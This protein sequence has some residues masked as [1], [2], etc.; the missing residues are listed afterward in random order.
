MRKFTS[1]LALVLCFF[2]ALGA[3]AQID[4]NKIIDYIGEPLVSVEEF[5]DGGLYLIT[6]VGRHNTDGQWLYETTDNSLL[7]ESVAEGHSANAAFTIEVVGDEQ[8]RIKTPSGNYV[9]VFN[10]SQGTFKS[11]SLEPATFII[12]PIDGA[13]G[14]FTL[15]YTDAN[16][17]LDANAANLSNW[18]D[19][20]GAGG[21]GAFRF[22]PVELGDP[23]AAMYLD[24]VLEKI[25]FDESEYLRDVPGGYP[26]ELIDAC[27]EAYDIA[28]DYQANGGDDDELREAADNLQAAYDAL[29]AAQIQVAFEPGNYYL[30]NARIGTSGNVLADAEDLSS[31][32]AAYAEGTKALWSENFDATIQGEEANPAY[33]W[34]IEAAGTNDAGD[35]LY[36]IKNLAN[37]AYLNNVTATVTTYGFTSDVNEAGKFKIGTSSA[38]AGFITITNSAINSQYNSLHSALSGQAVVNWEAGAGASAW[39]VAP[40]D[41]ETI[42][43]M[44]EKIEELR[45]QAAQQAL[46]D[47]LQKYYTAASAA[48]EAGRTW[49]FD[50][51]ND[52]Q[53]AEL[54]GLLIDATQVWSN[55]KN[56]ASNEGTYEGLFDSK[57]T[58]D[59]LDWY[60]HTAWGA[61]E[62]EPTEPHYLQMDMG[63]EV[64]TLVL[65][66]AVRGNANAPDIP[67]NVVLYGTNDPSLL[68]NDTD[69]IPSTEWDNLGEYTMNWQYPL[70]D[71]DGNAISVSM[72]SGIRAVIPDG[73]GAGITTFELEKPYQY[74]RLSV[75]ENLQHIRQGS[76]RTH[77]DGFDYW[78]ISELR[79]YAGEYDPD[80]VYAHMDQEAIDALENSLAAAKE[81]LGESAAT[82]ETIDALK[83]AYEAFMAVYPDR[84]KLQAAI[85][86]AKSW[87][88]PAVEGAEIGNYNAGAKSAFQAAVDDAQSVADG[89]LTFATFNQAMAELQ[90]ANE[91]FAAQLIL[92]ETGYY[93][94]QSLT[95]G[96]AKDAYLVAR[97][98]ST[99]AVRGS[100]GLGFKY[101]DESVAE[102]MNALWYV[103]KK[104][105][106]KFTFKNVASGLYMTN[107]QTTL[108]GAVAQVEEPAE[109]ALRAA[110]DS[111]GIALNFVIN[112]EEGLYG[113]AD[114]AGIFVVWNDAKGNDNSSWTFLPAV[115]TDLTLTID[116]T[117]PVTLHTLPFDVLTAGAAGSVYE[118]A[119]I[120]EDGQNVAF[121]AITGSTIEAG[122]PFVI[123][124]DPEVTPQVVFYPVDDNA[125]TLTYVR[126]AKTVNGLVGTLQP[127]T[128]DDKFLVLNSASDKLI[129]AA[130]AQY[131][132][133]TANTGYFDWNA[134]QAIPAVASG[135]LLVALHEDLVNGIETLVAQP[136]A[137]Q[138]QGVYTLQ[139]QKVANTRNLPAGVYIINGRKVLV[140]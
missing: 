128:I 19:I 38:V 79:A 32:D 130:S 1:L 114:P 35:D 46:N 121:N 26:S 51:T 138:R 96:A 112:E 33:I 120:T 22:A 129:Y 131:Q 137:L 59:G 86:E 11:S 13:D 55:C 123:S 4:I 75:I 7:F 80:C 18:Y 53:F 30:V 45:R 65:K 104:E 90:A 44:A 39:T 49:I 101:A 91:A 14:Q 67:Y 34:Q 102:R 134:L 74:F 93:N 83:A 9:P 43:A 113:N 54:D 119:G 3:Q 116:V 57:V 108:S 87:I 36:T 92:P 68:A 76:P 88:T 111:M 15:K 56:T 127:D 115:G 84:N 60:F 99:T 70:L 12:A 103:E 77:G 139:G 71:A 17:Y 61:V 5:E 2:A 16:M 125:E 117:K 97:T 25:I 78:T 85:D 98:T 41:D 42:D 94:I 24:A 132:N 10:G 64:Q 50:G 72:L 135:D 105:N 140:K 118:V 29:L 136:A 37:D 63:E 28:V 107:T 66:Y 62:T 95:T 21:N 27:Q 81:E 8:I 110:R 47:T 52:G 126:E 124:V 69:T 40:V 20:S 48:R 31:V 106:G 23:T 73:Q 58:G 100:A 6:S 133:I 82:Q 122:T 109:I 89:T